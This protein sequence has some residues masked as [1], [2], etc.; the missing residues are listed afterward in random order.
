[1]SIE[2]SVAHDNLKKLVSAYSESG[3]QANE[4]QTRFSFI[5]RMLEECLDWPKSETEVE[6][7][8]SEGRTDY[9]LGRPRIFIV[10]AKASRDGFKIPPKRARTRMPLQSLMRFDEAVHDA[11]TQAQAY[12]AKRGVRPVAVS[13]GSQL[14]AF[15]ATRDDGIAPLEGDAVVLDG[16]EE[17]LKHFNI[18]YCI[19]HKWSFVGFNKCCTTKEPHI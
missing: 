1:M 6:V 3:E 4:A 2:Y 15:L 13:N 8:E 18:I 10:E 11:V 19:R 16:F 14:I 9:E 17:L 5:D 12:G 7:F